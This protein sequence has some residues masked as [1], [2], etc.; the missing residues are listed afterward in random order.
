MAFE[1]LL[2]RDTRPSKQGS[3]PPV[4][5]PPRRK[6]YRKKYVVVT[7][8]TVQKKYEVVTK[9]CVGRARLAFLFGC[10]WLLGTVALLQVEYGLVFRVFF[11]SR[12]EQVACLLAACGCPCLA[13]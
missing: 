9:G 4:A 5:L 10:S 12:G 3:K 13:G 7:K 6:M 1:V 2:R 8:E 11:S